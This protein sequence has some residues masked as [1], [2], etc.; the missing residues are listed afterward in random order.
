MT[1]NN[2]FYVY[3]FLREDGTPYYI[4]KGSGNR[5]YKDRGRPCKL[6]KDTNRIIKIAENLTEEVAFNLEKKLILEYGRKD[7]RTGILYNRTNGGDGVS[8]LIVTEQTRKKISLQTSGE[9]NPFFGKTHSEKTR[10]LISNKVSN[11]PPE[12]REKVRKK[13]IG[14]KRSKEHKEKIS[15][16]TSGEKNPFFGKNHSIEAKQ[17]ISEANRGRIQT[18]EEIAKRSAALKGRKLSEEHCKKISEIHKG[19]TVNKETK[20]KIKEARA[21]QVM[22]PLSE[23]TKKKLSLAHKG[24]KLSLDTRKKLSD[25]KK[26]KPWSEKRRQA[27]IKKQQPIEL[28]PDLFEIIK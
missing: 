28:N 21:R 16:Q 19:K 24:K 10:K 8:G 14:K 25:F 2:I 18:T 20:Q 27:Q 17:K 7:I 6:P 5:C 3:Q 11:L 4:G 23:E 15:L 26:G 12:W 22:K 9:K 1:D 13:L